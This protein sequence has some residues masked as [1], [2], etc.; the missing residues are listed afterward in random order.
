MMAVKQWAKDFKMNSAK[1]N[2]I[3]SY[4]WINL[5]VFYLQ[6]LG[7]VPNLQSRDLM[8]AVGLVPDPKDNYWHFV[9]EL[10]TCTIKWD[11]VKTANA[12]TMPS[13]LQDMPVS[14]L[15][16][17]FFEFYSRRFPS[18]TFAVSIKKGDISLPKLA[19]R[20][21]SLFYCI[22]DPFET[23]D[24]HC[25]HDLGTPAGE[26]ATRD[27]LNF[28]REG[29]AHLRD[30]LCGRKKNV[31]LWPDPPFIEPQPSRKSPK[32]AKFSHFEPPVNSGV[33]PQTLDQVSS[34]Q[35]EQRAQQ[36]NGGGEHIEQRQPNQHSRKG[37]Q[38]TKPRS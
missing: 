7:F 21:R 38:R 4:A 20:K 8:E 18:A 32:N 5:V 14:A 16:Y 35:Q 9:N 26:T 12:W 19:F 11:Q 33:D 10:D 24:S 31:G 1:D 13:E 27:M 22:E 15:L 29:E 2:F 6:C 28:F 23:Y 37:R 3:S 36:E 30:V 34:G 17:G 25:P